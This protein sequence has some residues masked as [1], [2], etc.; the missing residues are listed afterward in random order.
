MEAIAK[1]LSGNHLLLVQQFPDW[2]LGACLAG[3]WWGGGL[4][5]AAMGEAGLSGQGPLAESARAE[6]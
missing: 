1:L 6:T 3:S 2:L 4:S 5:A